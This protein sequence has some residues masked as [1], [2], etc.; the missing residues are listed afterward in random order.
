MVGDT[1][2]NRS[3]IRWDD[4][5]EWDE[6]RLSTYERNTRILENNNQLLADVIKPWK[7]FANAMEKSQEPTEEE[8]L[9]QEVWAVQNDLYK[10]CHKHA[11]KEVREILRHTHEYMAETIEV[12]EE[13]DAELRSH[14][15]QFHRSSA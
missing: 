12:L 6:E 13:R 8:K 1:M 5:P 3:D 14:P 2:T 11:F 15:A 10:L 7:E 4:G 9:E